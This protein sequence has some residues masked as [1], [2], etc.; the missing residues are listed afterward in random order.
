MSSP[1]LNF[2][3]NIQIDMIINYHANHAEELEGFSID[4]YNSESYMC[5][6]GL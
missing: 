1:T 6:S 5:I 4:P 3:N 2:K